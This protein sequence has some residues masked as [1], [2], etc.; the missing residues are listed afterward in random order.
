[1]PQLRQ[2]ASTEGRTDVADWDNGTGRV[3]T[4]NTIMYQLWREWE[5]QCVEKE[6]RAESLTEDELRMSTGHI[7]NT[8]K[9]DATAITGPGIYDYQFDMRE[10]EYLIIVPQK[11]LRR[12][13]C[14]FWIKKL[15]A[16]YSKDFELVWDK[17]TE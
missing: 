16:K 13:V 10:T 15:N 12:D 3:V 9:F 1:M 7:A 6:R 11:T 14:E 5:R 17:A 2:H 8:T 4:F